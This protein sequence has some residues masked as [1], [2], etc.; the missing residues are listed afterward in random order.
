MALNIFQNKLNSSSLAFPAYFNIILI[1]TS[2][3]F[4]NNKNKLLADVVL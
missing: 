3:L 4:K 2:N 1:K